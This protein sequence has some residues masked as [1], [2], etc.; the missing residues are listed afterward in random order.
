M[1]KCSKCG[2]MQEDSAYFCTECGSPD[3][4]EAPLQYNGKSGK[5][6]KKGKKKVVGIT[7]GTL[8]AILITAIPIGIR[9]GL[10][11][12]YKEQREK[13]QLS[14]ITDFDY[15]AIDDILYTSGEIVDGKYINEWAGIQFEVPEKFPLYDNYKEFDD[16]TA[17][18]GYA[19]MEN[20]KMLSL[21]FYDLTDAE[22]SLDTDTVLDEGTEQFIEG[23][24]VDYVVGDKY[25][26][27]IADKD[28]RAVDI[29]DPDGYYLTYC[30][31]VKNKRV[32]EFC[33]GCDNTEDIDEFF[34]SV[35]AVDYEST[36]K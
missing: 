20:G 3:L 1:K 9:Q 12:Y 19:C 28:F 34:N 18:T 10:S 35:E 21:I 16:E 5:A 22:G 24:D 23:T 31:Y 7:S 25:T 29:L 27:T 11:D 14:A 30:I 33:V 6:K 15:E 26:Y 36:D 2:S 4:V 13:E 8:A 32:I 17:E